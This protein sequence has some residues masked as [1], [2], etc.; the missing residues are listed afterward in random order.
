MLDA[1]VVAFVLVVAKQKV[2]VAAAAEYS[3]LECVVSAAVALV[4]SS[5]ASQDSPA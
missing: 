2:A 4:C 3:V 5:A 1:F